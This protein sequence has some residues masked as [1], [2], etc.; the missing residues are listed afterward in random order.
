MYARV[1]NILALKINHGPKAWRGRWTWCGGF[2]FGG[3]FSFRA[4]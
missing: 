3:A 2:N 4:V 1:N